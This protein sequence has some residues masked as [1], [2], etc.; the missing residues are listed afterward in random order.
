M[1][2]LFTEENLTL[3]FESYGK[4]VDISI[5]NSSMDQVRII[6]EGL[7]NLSK[8]YLFCGTDYG[9][10]L[11]RIPLHHAAQWHPAGIWF[12]TL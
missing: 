12:R 4:V 7:R 11:N 10:P 2:S 8:K 9:L 1:D 3:F 5:K 6:D